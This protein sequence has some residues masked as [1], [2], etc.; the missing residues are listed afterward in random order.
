M[1]SEYLMLRHPLVGETT[2]L[3]F[4]FSW[5]LDNWLTDKVG[6]PLLVQR[7]SLNKEIVIHQVPGNIALTI[8][9]KYDKLAFWIKNVGEIL[10]KRDS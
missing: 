9:L 10:Q 4:S 2:Y 3:V 8:P 7:T 1:K 6:L 5:D